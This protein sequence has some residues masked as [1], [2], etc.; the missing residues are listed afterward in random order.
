MGI[1]IY[2]YFHGMSPAI[3]ICKKCKH[4]VKKGFNNGHR[5]VYSCDGCDS[6]VTLTEWK[7]EII[8]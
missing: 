4:P 5:D 2:K 1:Y 7:E 8:A 3:L 6:W